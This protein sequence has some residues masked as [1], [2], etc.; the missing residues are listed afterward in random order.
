MCC[1]GACD[2]GLLYTLYLRRGGVVQCVVRESVSL[3]GGRRVLTSPPL[4][5]LFLRDA[6]QLQVGHEGV[7]IA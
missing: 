6:R 3:K 4:I 5:L 7:R 2:Y 1:T